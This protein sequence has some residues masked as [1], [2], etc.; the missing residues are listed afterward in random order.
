MMNGGILN[1]NSVLNGGVF[2]Q[3]SFNSLQ[4]ETTIF[5]TASSSPDK[6]KLTKQA[7][8]DIESDIETKVPNIVDLNEI[9]TKIETEEAKECESEKQVEQEDE[10]KEINLS[11][12][13]EHNIK[14]EVEINKIDDET[15]TTK[16]EEKDEKMKMS[17][18]E[19]EN[20]DEAMDN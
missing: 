6:I 11:S 13:N 20:I 5:E 15:T 16:R 4:I 18:S 8:I 9:S 2:Y 17:G 7:K 10:K 12:S 3:K 19:N 1:D 14:T